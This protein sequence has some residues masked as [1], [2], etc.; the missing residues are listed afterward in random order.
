M[1]YFCLI[2]QLVLLTAVVLFLTFVLL[3]TFRAV[4]IP[5]IW[6]A[7]YQLCFVCKEG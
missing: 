1:E 2:V 7:W 5:R 4:E 3:I 6:E